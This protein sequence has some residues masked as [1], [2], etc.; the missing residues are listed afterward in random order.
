MDWRPGTSTTALRARAEFLG[1]VRGFFAERGVLEVD[2]P[3]LASRTVTE[4]AIASV[5]AEGGWLQTS[6]EYF[7]KRLLA[8]GSGPIYQIGRAFRAGERGR[9]HNPEF[10]LLEW[11][12]PGFDDSELMAELEALLAPHVPGFPA[13]RC[14]F[15][16][17]VGERFGVDAF[18]ATEHELAAALTTAWAGRGREG[19]A[20]EL[21]EGRREGLLDLLYADACDATRGAVL[22]TDFPSEMA[23]LARLRRDAAG[24]TVAA[25]FELVV[26]GV[27]LA[28][29]FHELTDADEQRRRFEADLDL[30]RLRDLPVPEIDEQLLAALAAGLPDCAGVAVGLDRVLM[31]ALG[32]RSLDAVVPF[33]QPRS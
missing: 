19:D 22:V 9:L 27:E 13:R 17:L 4:P 21:A 10:L 28:N 32:E 23:A 25:R 1:A 29:G 31:L 30:R 16:S 24:R 15:A 20:L 6:P 18:A 2:T 14:P 5:A 7:M 26:D 8:A 11:Y 3:V 33:T 12:R